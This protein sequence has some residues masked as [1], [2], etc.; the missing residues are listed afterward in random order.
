MVVIHCAQ[1]HRN[2]TAAAN[3]VYCRVEG[4]GGER[5]RDTELTAPFADDLRTF[6]PYCY[7]N[8]WV[9]VVEGKKLGACRGIKV[10]KDGAE[11]ANP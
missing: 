2:P 5:T 6:S 10:A 3:G 11:E 9:G 8:G 7:Q 4:A 1:A